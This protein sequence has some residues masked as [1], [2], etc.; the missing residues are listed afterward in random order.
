[1]RYFLTALFLAGMV[2]LSAQQLN[3]AESNNTFA[4]HFF[5][6]IIKNS[7]ENTVVSPYSMSSALA[8]VYP[9]AKS[10]TAVQMQSALH[11]SA[12][13][14]QHQEGFRSLFQAIGTNDSTLSLS[15]RVWIG[16][17]ETIDAQF[18]RVNAEYFDSDIKPMDFRGSPEQ[19]RSA[20]NEVIADETRNQI[21]DLLPAGSIRPA[22]TMVLTNAV[23]FKDSWVKPFDKK[24][25][26]PGAFVLRSGTAV[27]RSF[28]ENAGTFNYF[29]DE[30]VSVL[31]LPYQ[32]RAFELLIV[33]PKR[34]IDQVLPY[35]TAKYYSSWR[36]QTSRFEKI[37][38]PKFTISK[39]LDPEPI[40]KSFGLV[41]LFE[42]GKADLSGIS[43]GYFVA[44]IFHQAFIDV[45]EQGT[46]AAAATAVVIE[47]ESIPPMAPDFVA[48]KPFIFILRHTGTNSIVFI[49]KVEDPQPSF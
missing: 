23:Y 44:D 5:N 18:L 45:N 33:L 14:Q 32:N 41:D 6:D 7:Q 3:C 25:T 4:L 38:I 12:N 21:R 2:P 15:N 35:L 27:Q 43:R 11:F 1:M 37:Q 19:S 48:G 13:S 34:T 29:S 47:P 36:F 16:K 26:K 28:M 30:V 20:I 17:S 42:K 8:M 24:R 10:R 46:T 22:T 40:L 31:G 49:G 9:G 39:K